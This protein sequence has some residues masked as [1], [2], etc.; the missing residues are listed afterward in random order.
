M[1]GKKSF[2]TNLQKIETCHTTKKLKSQ[3]WVILQEN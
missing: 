3:T 2:S 1:E